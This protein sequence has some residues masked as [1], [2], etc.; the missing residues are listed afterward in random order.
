[1]GACNQIPKPAINASA[2]SAAYCATENL[3]T[4]SPSDTPETVVQIKVHNAKYKAL[5]GA[6]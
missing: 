3:V 5:C 6:Q 4:W 2:F 1:M